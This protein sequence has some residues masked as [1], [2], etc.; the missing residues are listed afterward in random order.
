MKKQ[1]RC[2][3]LLMCAALLVTSVC[4]WTAPSYAASSVK[5]NIITNVTNPSSGIIKY[6]ITVPAG[7]TVKYALTLTPNRRMRNID[8][9]AGSYTNRTRKTVKKT[10]TAKVKYMTNKYIITATYTAK[11]SKQN[12]VYKDESRAT[13]RLKKTV[14][15]SKFTWTTKN[16][17]KWKNGQRLAAVL[18]FAVTGIMDVFVSKGAMSGSVATVI[19]LSMT[20]GNFASSGNVASTKKLSSTPIKGWGYRV[21]CVPCKDGYCQYLLVYNE[22]G[23]QV[24]SYKMFKMPLSKIA[25]LIK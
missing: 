25:L 3:L 23:K 24:N 11:S 13:S 19:G 2:L 15:S 22:K 21:K 16:I 10:V 6:T 18:T 5:R 17:K 4:T 14:Y 7:K 12:I 1:T 8:R 9:V 20:V